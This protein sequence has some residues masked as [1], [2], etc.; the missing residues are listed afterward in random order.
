MLLRKIRSLSVVVGV[1]LLLAGQAVAMMTKRRSKK[2]GKDILW[3]F[4]G[5]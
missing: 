1:L 5:G 4:L 2:A 3:P